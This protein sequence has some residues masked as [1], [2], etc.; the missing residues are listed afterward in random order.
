MQSDHT[1]MHMP[2]RAEGLVPPQSIIYAQ[3]HGPKPVCWWSLLL[4]SGANAAKL[5]TE[6]TA[7]RRGC[8]RQRLKLS[9]AS[10]S[11]IS[12]SRCYNCR[13]SV[14]RLG[15]PLPTSST[16]IP[17]WGAVKR[18]S[19][20][21]AAGPFL[22]LTNAARSHAPVTPKHAYKHGVSQCSIL[23]KLARFRMRVVS[24]HIWQD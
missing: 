5:L 20:R 17:I 10:V 23:R 16:C 12:I 18:R 4:K 13:L 21:R 22:S 15:V 19:E 11:A 7:G 9:R 3:V 8:R 14:N 24:S 2:D 1:H 6:Q